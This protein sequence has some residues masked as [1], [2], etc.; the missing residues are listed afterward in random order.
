MR[1]NA[2]YDA[3][4]FLSGSTGEHAASGIGWFLTALYLALLIA[5]IAIACI[6]WSQD[7][8]QRTR[9]VCPASTL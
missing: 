4:L 6:N 1:T 5:S 2:F 7:A 9:A 8:S 3:W